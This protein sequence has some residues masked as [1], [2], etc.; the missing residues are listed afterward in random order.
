MDERLVA[1]ADNLAWEHGLRGYNAVHLAAGLI[2]QETIGLHV[3]LATYDQALW[4]A[5]G[6]SG[7][8]PWPKE[9]DP[10]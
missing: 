2:W 3:S 7:I 6:I 10:G 4:K 1:P 8:G 9:L 5:A